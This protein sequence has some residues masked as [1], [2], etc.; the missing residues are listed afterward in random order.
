MYGGKKVKNP[1]SISITIN[2]ILLPNT[3]HYRKIYVPSKSKYQEA[4]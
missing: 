3:N 1:L 2:P 4:S